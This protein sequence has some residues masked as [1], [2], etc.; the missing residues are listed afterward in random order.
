MF[1]NPSF[2]FDIICTAAWIILMIRYAHK[3]FLSSMVQLVGNLISL[4][5]ARQLSTAC[6]GWVF[7]HMLAGGFRTQIAASLSA[8]GVVDLTGIAEKYAGFLP[9]SFRASIV[10]ACER[11]IGAVLADNAVVLADTIVENVLQPL[12][13]PVITLVLFF[14]F[15]ARKEAGRKPAYFSAM[16]ERSTAPPAAMFAA[17]WV[18]KPP[19]SM[20]SNTQ[21]AQAAESSLAPSRLNRLPTSCTMDE[22]KPLRA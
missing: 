8:G 10:A 2:L 22:R 21:P 3:G 5:G 13:T 19:A 1:K 7:E 4:L 16:P 12:L 9:A 11:S 15:Y 20:C 6:A 14:L 18:R 17:I